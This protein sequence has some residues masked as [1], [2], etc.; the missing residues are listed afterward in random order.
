M[1]RVIIILT[2]SVMLLSFGRV[3]AQKG[4]ETMNFT[5]STSAFIEGETIPVKYTCD[6]ADL[7]PLMK[8]EGI[9]AGTKGFAIIMDDPDAP[10]GTFTHWVIYDIPAD[11]HTLPEGLAKDPELSKGIKQGTTSFRRT[12]YGGPCPPP[13]RPHRYF[14][15]IYALDTGTTGLASKASR[16]DVE[17]RIK[18]HITGKATVMG[19]YG[20]K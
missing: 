15:T 13:G 3:M 9:P 10:V 4:G 12:G 6:G 8:W 11:T 5:L 14:F 7:S 20:R 1:N 19:Q 2:F 16:Q 17:S 18:G